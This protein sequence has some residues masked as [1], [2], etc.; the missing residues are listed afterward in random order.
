MTVIISFPHPKMIIMAADSKRKLDVTRRDF[1]LRPLE[2]HV[3]YDDMTKVFPVPGIGCVTLWGYVNYAEEGFPAYLEKNISHI[4]NIEDLRHLVET[5]LRH[6][7]QADD[8]G[9]EIGFHVGG[10][11]PHGE[12]RLYHIFYGRDR[13]SSEGEIP[14]FHSYPSHD[15][16]ALYNGRNDFVS[17]IMNLLTSLQTQVGISVFNDDSVQRII[18][19]DFLT[20]YISSLTLDVGGEIHTML[21]RPDNSIFWVRNEKHLIIPREELT[22]LLNSWITT[23]NTE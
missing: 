19:A 20:R 11:T 9:E 12:P 3:E 13:P 17:P 14:D 22:S 4:Q 10:F 2:E 18:L 5:Y 21:I 8:P 16:L 6:D 7:L 23:S 1:D 15:R